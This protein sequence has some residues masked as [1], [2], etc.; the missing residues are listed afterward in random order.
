[1][2]KHAIQNSQ[3]PVLGFKTAITWAVLHYPLSKNLDFKNYPKYQNIFTYISCQN[4]QSKIQ[5]HQS[6]ALKQQSL[7]LRCTIL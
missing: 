3:P 2:A 5:N 6:L 7:E 1:M 4:K